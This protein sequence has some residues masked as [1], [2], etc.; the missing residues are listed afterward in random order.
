MDSENILTTAVRECKEEVGLM[1]SEHELK[2]HGI[3]EFRF[4]DSPK[5]NSCC[6]IY[7][8]AYNPEEQGVGVCVCVCECVCVCLIFTK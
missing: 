2:C 8:A 1:L 6:Y 4:V 7:T 5:H 3:I